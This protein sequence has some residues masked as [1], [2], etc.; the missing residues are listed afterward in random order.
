MKTIKKWITLLLFLYLGFSAQAQHYTNITAEIDNVAKTVLV[1]QEFTFFNQSNDTIK[2]IVFNDWNNAYCNKETPLAKRFSD[3]YV[4]NFHLAQNKDRGSTNNL[5]VIDEDKSILNWCRYDDSSD[6]VELHLK[7]AIAP[8]QK[9][10]FTLTYILKIPN[11]KFTGIG[12]N[13]KNEMT[14]KN[15]FLLPSRYENNDFLKYDNLNIDDQTNALFDID[16]KI[17]IPASF[18][19]ASDLIEQKR[20]INNYYF[21]GKNKLNLN[22]YLENKSTFS[23]YRNSLTDVW[24]NIKDHKVNPIHKA[25]LIDKIVDYVANNVATPTLPKIVVSENDYATNPFYGLNQLPSFISPFPDEFI[26]ELKFLKTYLNNYLKNSLQ[27]DNRK[28]NWIFDAIQVYYMMKYIDENYPEAKM[29]GSLAKFKLL[30]GFHFI[31]LDFNEQY[32]YFYMMMA[33]KNLDQPLGAPKNDLIKFNE[34]IA[35]KYRAGLSFRYLADYIG[36]NNLQSSITQF[37]EY[38]TANQTNVNYFEKIVAQNTPKNIDWFFQTIINSRDI[39]DYKFSNVEKTPNTVSFSLVNKT[40]VFVPIPVYGIKKNKIVFKEWIDRFSNDS[41][42]TFKRNDAE[43]IV[44]NY[45]NVVPEFNQ[46]NNWHSLKSFFV[47]HKPIKFNF[48]SDL[49]NPNYNQVLYVPDFDYNLYDGLI[50]GLRFHNKT[51]LNKPF[52]FDVT[53]S[54]STNSKSLSGSFSFSINQFHRE[55]SMFFSRYGISGNTFHYAPDA[56]YQRFTPYINFQFREKDNY[57]KNH[58]ESLSFREVYVN[59]EPSTYLATNTTTIKSDDFQGTYAVFDARYSKSVSELS[60]SFGYSTNVQVSSKFSK[61]IG[62][63]SFRKLFNDNR[64]ISARYYI[65]TFI[66]NNTTNNNYTFALDRPNDYL[67]D[68]NYFGRSE[69]SGFFSQQYIT[70]DGG[71]KSIIADKYANQML[72]SLN[73]S[74]SIWNW[75]ECYADAGFLQSKQSQMRFAYDSGIRLN[76]VQGYFEIYLPVQ[77]SNGFEVTQPHYSQKIRFILS[78]STKSLMGLFTRK[79]F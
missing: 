25:V 35:S 44:I 19:L 74:G 47:T 64:Q 75:V 62:E 9:Q 4:R 54:Y 57:R 68:Y 39:I 43:K 58:H 52:I 71:F 24:C 48:M 5:T 73:V 23:L 22:L 8:Q 20:E 13:N 14:L 6:Y 56:S 78:F 12:F 79:W 31:S 41:I 53:P 59:K 17:T 3:E 18:D 55:K 38:A 30:K 76:L 60:K 45:K 32:S 49:E 2:H 50:L 26:F 10:I 70:A 66:H 61:L 11:D 63:I 7:K 15:C 46:R 42:Y 27:I 29:M 21:S 1:Y 69:D 16:L 67:F 77:S 40:N 37:V 33:R 34:K 72:T 65:G 28:D 51:L 36:E